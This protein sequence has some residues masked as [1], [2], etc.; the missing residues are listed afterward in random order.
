M[1]KRYQIPVSLRLLQRLVITLSIGLLVP[2]APF[3][4]QAQDCSTN[5]FPGP[6]NHDN[7]QVELPAAINAMSITP[8]CPPDGL[9]EFQNATEFAADILSR[10]GIAGDLALATGRSPDPGGLM[11]RKPPLS[12]PFNGLLQGYQVASFENGQGTVVDLFYSVYGGARGLLLAADVSMDLGKPGIELV[13]PYASAAQGIGNALGL[14]MALL[15]VV[16]FQNSSEEST[17]VYS[18]SFDGLD[19][20]GCNL[21]AFTCEN[22]TG[23]LVEMMFLPYLNV[24][25][26]SLGITAE[27]A[28]QIAH[29]SLPSVIIDD[30][31]L[32][33][34]EGVT[35]IA[36]TIQP[37]GIVANSTNSSTGGSAEGRLAYEYEAVLRGSAHEGLNYS[38]LVLVDYESG[39]ILLSYRSPVPVPS[40]HAYIALGWFGLA[41]SL[42]ICLFVVLVLASPEFAIL[43]MGSYLVFVFVRLRGANVLYNFNRGRIMGLVSAKPG[44]SFTEIRDSL[45][46]ANGGLAYHLSVLEKL[47]LLS[48]EKQGRVRRFFP[49]G[50]PCPRGEH[51]FLGKTESRIL[52]QLDERGPLSNSAIAGFLGM[53]R[54]R[55][56]YNLRLLK[57]RGL[58]DQLG[59]LWKTALARQK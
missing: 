7:P 42:V 41:L 9:S 15:P 26:S 30:R 45:S 16:S 1:A 24:S 18:A 56:H 10:L 11:W 34:H 33:T 6:S 46:I 4:S 59:S 35:A 20:V 54:Q 38:V 31:D 49:V 53:S 25:S 19:L 32:I 5:P 52:E 48:S 44:A 47:E 2:I 22:E 23:R 57:R 39:S 50:I 51:H 21:A 58:V 12:E 43:V 3:A 36:Y 40:S 13:P 37:A 14:P 28:T 27:L 29:E 17:V 55:T 8:S